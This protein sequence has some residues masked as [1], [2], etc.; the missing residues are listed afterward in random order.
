MNDEEPKDDE[1]ESPLKK[2]HRVKVLF[3]I[4]LCGWGLLLLA[5]LFVQLLEAPFG[6]PVARTLAA[7]AF[8]SVPVVF[9]WL[10]FAT[11]FSSWGIL[12]ANDWRNPAAFAAVQLFAM[13]VTK[14]GEWHAPELHG[15]TALLAIGGI[16]GIVVAAMWLINLLVMIPVPGPATETW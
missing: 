6:D 14:F 15:G 7:V 5:N 1:F 2:V 4:P 3:A 16:A 8:Y 11:V 13:I 12:D 10:V 9:L